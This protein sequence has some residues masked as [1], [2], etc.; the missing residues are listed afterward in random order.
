METL[1]NMIQDYSLQPGTLLN[2]VIDDLQ[3]CNLHFLMVLCVTLLQRGSVPVLRKKYYPFPPFPFNIPSQMKIV[4]YSTYH[5]LLQPPTCPPTPFLINHIFSWESK[6]KHTDV[7]T[8]CFFQ[9]IK[10]SLTKHKKCLLEASYGTSQTSK[11]E[12]FTKKR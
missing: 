11:V 5:F 1:F 7:D 6:L 4:I 2:S 10:S 8:T 3:R 12:L 9:D